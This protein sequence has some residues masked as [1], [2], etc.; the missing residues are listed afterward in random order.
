MFTYC[1]GDIFASD[2]DAL[3]N[4]VNCKGVMGKGLAADFKKKYP[5]N[6]QN[7]RNECLSQRL[8]T[9]KLSI[10]DEKGKTIINFPTKDDWRRP[11]KLSYI[12]EGLDSLAE[13]LNHSRIKSIAIPKLGCGIG[14]LDWTAVRPL[15]EEKLSPISKTIRIDIYGEPDLSSENAEPLKRLVLKNLVQNLNRDP[16]IE[17]LAV[18]CCF[19]DYFSLNPIFEAK[20][21]TQSSKIEYGE[22]TKQALHSILLNLTE[23]PKNSLDK[24]IPAVRISSDINRAIKSTSF[25]LN[26]IS[27]KRDLYILLIILS[28]LTGLGNS[29][30]KSMNKDEVLELIVRQLPRMDEDT[31]KKKV[32]ELLDFLCELGYLAETLLGYEILD[33]SYNVYTDSM[34]CKT[35]RPAVVVSDYESDSG[36]N[37][38]EISERTTKEYLVSIN[39]DELSELIK[40]PGIG[41]KTA[42]KIIEYRRKSGDFT[43]LE[44][45]KLV[46]GIKDK[47]FN[48]VKDKISI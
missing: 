44:E 26:E 43:S 2:A 28:Q 6:Y 17:I 8:T 30:L 29:G 4:A 25:V 48:A 9:G 40:L 46:P 11:S 23:R 41:K 18:A 45:L 37:A 24:S 20:L 32:L 27:V 5:K 33:Y 7:Y 12:S 16:D 47:A 14:G 34:I 38:A 13:Y 21:N 22:N 36:I 10:F 3:I 42:E 39:T 35:T 15:I 31:A 19:I 1:E